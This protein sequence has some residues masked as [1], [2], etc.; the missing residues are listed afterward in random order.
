MQLD[1]IGASV[2]ATFADGELRMDGAST[3]ALTGALLAAMATADRQNYALGPLSHPEQVAS[4]EVKPP[5]EVSHPVLLDPVMWMV[6]T[7][8]TS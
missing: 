2:A 5:W 1:V 4:I 7:A 8:Y 3:T 6:A